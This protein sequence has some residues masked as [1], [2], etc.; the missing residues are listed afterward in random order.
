MALIEMVERV[1]RPPVAEFAKTVVAVVT[2]PMFAPPQMFARLSY[3]LLASNA[4]FSSIY[5]TFNF[6]LNVCYIV[7][8]RLRFFFFF[9]R[10]GPRLRVTQEQRAGC[11]VFFEILFG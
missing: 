4:V 8:D 3:I 7:Q 1:A 9:F 5:I 6:P 10:P 11:N 2:P